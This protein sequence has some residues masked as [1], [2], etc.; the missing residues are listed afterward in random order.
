[1]LDE[2]IVRAPQDGAMRW[3]PWRACQQAADGIANQRL[4]GA[5][6]GAG[7]DRAGKTGARLLHDGHPWAALMDF[8]GIGVR[9]NGPRRAEH[10][11][12]IGVVLLRI[13]RG[14]NRPGGLVAASTVG[15]TIP[16]TL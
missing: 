2:R 11:D 4:D 1:M 7:L 6:R 3:L 16:R 15:A 8:L 13:L 10:G 12:H 14:R 9:G 5:F